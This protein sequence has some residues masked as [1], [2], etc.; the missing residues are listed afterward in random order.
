MRASRSC[1]SGA[2]VRQ[3]GGASLQVRRE[4]AAEVRAAPSAVVQRWA[5]ARWSEGRQRAEGRQQ[6]TFGGALVRWCGVAAPSRGGGRKRS[7]EA[8]GIRRAAWI[9]RAELSQRG[10]ARSGGGRADSRGGVIAAVFVRRSH[11]VSNRCA[12]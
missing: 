3:C 1:S 9:R 12:Q 8:A 7:E 11:R 6:L 4:E 10:G 5:A 2:L